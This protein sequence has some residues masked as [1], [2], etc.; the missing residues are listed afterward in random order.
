L[1]QRMGTNQAKQF[2][3]S[4]KQVQGNNAKMLGFVG[5]ITEDDALIHT[6]QLL[7]QLIHTPIQ[8]MLHTNKVY[9]YKN[10]DTLIEYLAQEREAQ[11]ELGSTYDHQEGVSAFLE[12]RKPL[13][14]GE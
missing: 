14:R 12:K 1:E 8:S 9:R 11:W 4:M 6:K 7:T 2:I 5:V 13:F 3:W 10:E